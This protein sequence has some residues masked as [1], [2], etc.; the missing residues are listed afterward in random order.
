MNN[1]NRKTTSRQTGTK[2]H[3]QSEYFPQGGEKRTG[4]NNL[5]QKGIML[6]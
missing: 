6:S 5:F 4:E 2:L 1:E 3:P